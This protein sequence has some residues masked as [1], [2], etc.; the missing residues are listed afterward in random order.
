MF[1]AKIREYSR[2]SEGADKLLEAF[3]HGTMDLFTY[4]V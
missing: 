3:M 4:D 2:S 1:S